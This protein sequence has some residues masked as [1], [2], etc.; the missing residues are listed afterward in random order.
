MNV[1]VY[2]MKGMFVL[3]KLRLVKGKYVDITVIQDLPV[4]SHASHISP[5]SSVTFHLQETSCPYD[6]PNACWLSLYVQRLPVCLPFGPLAPQR[7][8][9]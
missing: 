5:R 3:R 8:G 4:L 6:N 9:R 7:P 2:L 1:K